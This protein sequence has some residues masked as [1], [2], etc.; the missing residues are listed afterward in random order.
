MHVFLSRQFLKMTAA[1]PLLLLACGEKIGIGE[2]DGRLVLGTAAAEE[3]ITRSV[4]LND[5]ML[6]LE[7]NAGS[8]HLTGTDAG[9]TNIE[10]VKE[11][12]GSSEAAARE[13]LNE[14]QID[15][16]GSADS[17]RYI[18][19]SGEPELTS[20]SVRGE[21]PKR[22]NIRIRTDRGPVALS[23]LEGPIRIIHL[24][25]DIAIGGAR[26]S[27]EVQNR[28]GDVTVGLQGL[29]E[30]AVIQLRTYNGDIDLTIPETVSVDLVAETNAGDISISELQFTNRSFSPHGAGASFRGQ[31][32]NG[33]A[34]VALRTENGSISIRKGRVLEL[35]PE[36]PLPDDTS[37]V[38]EEG[39]PVSPP[40]TLR[41]IPPEER[42][43]SIQRPDADTTT[44]FQ[45][46]P[47]SVR[48]P[49][50]DE[51]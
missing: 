23:G 42:D 44:E 4:S 6:V 40:D 49:M 32:G 35:T 36:T 5:R 39:R 43:T 2:E 33:N 41:E 50:D 20:V 31:L 26:N 11:A 1:L 48:P 46:T 34:Q 45:V 15:E 47:D 30:N 37:G 14:V 24:Y 7:G 16:S 21:V 51:I 12:R 29:E 22:A 38:I 27:V 3:V 18:M 8:I 9:A 13:L 17:Y 10:F 25:G 19:R 28:S